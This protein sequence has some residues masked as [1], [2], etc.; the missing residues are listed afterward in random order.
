MRARRRLLVGVLGAQ[1]LDPPSSLRRAARGLMRALGE[2]AVERPLGQLEGVGRPVVAV[3][4][5]HRA[6][7]ALPRAARASADVSWSRRARARRCRRRIVTCGIT[8]RASSVDDVVDRA[9]VVEVPAVDARIAA[10]RARPPIFRTSTVVDAVLASSSAY[11]VRTS[12]LVAV[13]L[14]RPVALLAGLARGPQVLHRRRGSGAS[15]VSKVTAKS[16]RVPDSFER[17]NQPAP[18]PMWHCTQ[19]TR[20]CG[21]SSVGRVLAAPSRCGRPCRRTASSPCTRRPCRTPCPG[22]R[23]SATVARPTSGQP[24]APVGLLE[25]DLR[26]VLR[27]ARRGARSS[28]RRSRCR[29]GSA[30][31]PARRGPAGSRKSTMPS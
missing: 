14:L 28:R 26:V 11:F 10:V 13:E 25:V 12:E 27:A 18:G 2:R 4:A 5:V 8:W 22:S 9:T 30:A 20:A 21:E 15:T 19:P 29:A 23:R 31:G 16:W 24:V 17:T 7:L 3:H 6:P 1:Q